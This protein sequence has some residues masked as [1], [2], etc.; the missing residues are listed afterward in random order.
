[1]GVAMDYEDPQRT[2]LEAIDRLELFF[3]SLGV[4]TKLS[5]VPGVENLDE[6]VME[7]MAKRVRVVHEDGAIGW[8]KRLYTEDIVEIFKLAM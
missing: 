5:D 8:V 2:V 6:A 1:M 3:Q 4:P 7:K